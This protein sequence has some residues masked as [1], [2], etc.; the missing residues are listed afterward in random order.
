MNSQ[1]EA[2]SSGA[3]ACSVSSSSMTFRAR[4]AEGL[5]AMGAASGAGS[6]VAAPEVGVD[7]CSAIVGAAVLMGSAEEGTSCSALGAGIGSTETALSA[8]GSARLSVPSLGVEAAL[9]GPD[10]DEASV[11]ALGAGSAGVALAEEGSASAGGA[12]TGSAADELVS[13]LVSGT[14]STGIEG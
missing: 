9:K 11:A 13:A 5:G 3:E 8:A 7:V 6:A 10:E 2:S 1:A 4:F 12:L 14:A